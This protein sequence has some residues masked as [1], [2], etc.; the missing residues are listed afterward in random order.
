MLY[1]QQQLLCSPAATAATA[2]VEVA[3]AAYLVCGKHNGSWSAANMATV[4]LACLDCF[5]LCCW[6]RLCRFVC[7][8]LDGRAART[9]N[10]T[11][12][13]GAVLDM[14]TDR[15]VSRHYCLVMIVQKATTARPDSS[16]SNSCSR[17]TY[18]VTN[19]QVGLRSCSFCQALPGS[20][21]S[22]SANLESCCGRF[23]MQKELQQQRQGK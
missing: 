2:G 14:V 18:N 3:A 4:W 1:M 7:D 8:E 21:S 12:T 11:S 20:S 16:S 10:Q 6:H 15:W 5:N 9:F 13:M 19:R 23:S 17:H 22:S